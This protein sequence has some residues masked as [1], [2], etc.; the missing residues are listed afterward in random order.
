MT[1]LCQRIAAWAVHFRPDE[2]LLTLARQCTRDYAAC[3]VAGSQRAEM[4]PALAL[5]RPG[6]V[7]VWGVTEAF[8]APSAALV[9]G[10]AGSLLQLHDVYPPAGIHPSCAV[11]PAALAAA[12]LNPTGPKSLLSAIVVGYEVSNRFGDACQP[13]Q[14]RA[15]STPTATAGALGA[16]LAAG[17]IRGFD[18]PTLARALSLVTMLMPQM[19]GVA[20][21]A[22][23]AAVPLHGGL[24]ARA[25]IEATILALTTQGLPLVL[26]GDGRIGGFLSLLR[27]DAN[28]LQ[29]DSW[30]GTTMS[31][32]IG[33]R[34]PACFGSYAALEAL[35]SLPRAAAATVRSLRVGLPGRLLP[36]IETGPDGGG[37]YDRL[38]SVRWV[39]AR[40]LERGALSWHDVDDSA[41]TQQI[42]ARISVFHDAALDELP[43]DVLAANLDMATER[44]V[45]C[46]WRRALAEP[47]VHGSTG[48][49]RAADSLAWQDKF[50]A[51]MRAAPQV[52]QTLDTLLNEA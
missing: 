8:D 22:H 37:L 33:K 1:D 47:T 14:A 48:T 40:T 19:P 10:T 51:L 9:C 26:E 20:V 49:L 23:A 45:R 36:I 52:M 43:T 41:T 5:A 24:A 11:I 7:A 29:P 35:F 50:V 2:A 16:V 38:M 12:A 44:T 13:E 30:D 42:A 25:A 3:V 34:W 28:R 21:R 39:L 15:G 27:G 6:S 31:A 18:V 32:V 4:A 46:E 17:V